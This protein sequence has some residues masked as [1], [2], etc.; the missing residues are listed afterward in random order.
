MRA[1][2]SSVLLCV[3]GFSDSHPSCSIC[4]YAGATLSAAIFCI[5]V[6]NLISHAQSSTE[7]KLKSQKMTPSQTVLV[8][9]SR[10]AILSRGISAPYFDKHFKLDKVVD[11]IADRRV[12]WKYTIGEYEA[13][14]NDEIGFYTDENGR[15]VDV[16]GI[17]DVIGSAQDITRTIRRRRAEQLMSKCLGQ[18]TSGGILYQAVGPDRRAALLF[19]ASSLPIFLKSGNDMNRPVIYTAFINL[20]TGVCAKGMAQ[21]G[22]PRAPGN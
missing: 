11:N 19:T 20:E 16:H 5:L 12:V 6:L 18:Y 2:K 4:I 14:L 17:R 1:P 7:Q 22:R 3:G 10:S 8:Q 21:A 15:R 13:L 9:G